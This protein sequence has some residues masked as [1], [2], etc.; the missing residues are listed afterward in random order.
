MSLKSGKNIR[1]PGGAAL[2]QKI[3]CFLLCVYFGYNFFCGGFL[4]ALGVNTEIITHNFN[5]KR[6]K[7]LKY[8]EKTSRGFNIQ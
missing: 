7:P 2:R 5:K 3:S 6:K 8:E 1:I 4:Q